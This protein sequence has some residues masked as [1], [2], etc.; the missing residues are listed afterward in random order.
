MR[1]KTAFNAVAAAFMFLAAMCP[2]WAQQA[3]VK[4]YDAAKKAR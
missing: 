2:A 3:A 1:Q 4:R